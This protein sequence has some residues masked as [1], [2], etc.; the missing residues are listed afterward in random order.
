MMTIYLVKNEL[1]ELYGEYAEVNRAEV[2]AQTRTLW[3]DE[4]YYHV[5][6]LELEA[7]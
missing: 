6:L 4:H 7:A 1:N 2:D 3:D 5:E